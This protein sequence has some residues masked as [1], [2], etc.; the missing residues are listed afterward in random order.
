MADTGDEAREPTGQH[1]PEDEAGQRGQAGESTR[2]VAHHGAQPRSVSSRL[3]R[4]LAPRLTRA[5]L[6]AA[7]LSA[8]VGFAL[9]V[10]VTQNQSDDL[11][12]LRQSDLVRLLDEVSQRSDALSEEKASLEAQIT[13][14]KNGS[15]SNAAALRAA[16]LAAE[17]QGILAGRLPA[18][19][20][21]IRLTVG[22]DTSGITAAN[23][24]N[25]LEELRNAG[26]EAMS[27]DDRRVVVSTSFTDGPSGV[28]MDGQPLDAPFE[29]A[30]IGE[31]STLQPALEIPGGA[32]AVLRN[33]GADAVVTTVDELRI[34]A[35]A[36]PQA[37]RYATPSA[38]P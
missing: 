3:L 6:L 11:A 12:S 30:V 4:A 13:E 25:V 14:L 7:L 23:L 38:T 27:L 35:V 2:T 26:A 8:V 21:G 24:V 20:P 5:Q 29:W 1:M 9:V 36:D 22:G 15:D 10:Q 17:T 37:P 19:G 28:E 16:K 18:V 31:P 34:T 32:L 33:A